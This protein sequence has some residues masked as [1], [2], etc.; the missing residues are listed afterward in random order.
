[1]L[2]CCTEL[3]N[4]LYPGT[5]QGFTFGLIPN[6]KGFHH[7]QIFIET[8]TD[9]LAWRSSEMIRLSVWPRERD[10]HT[11]RR[12]QNQNAGCNNSLIRDHRIKTLDLSWKVGPMLIWPTCSDLSRSHF[13]WQ[14]ETSEDPIVE[15]FIS[16][17]VMNCQKKFDL[18]RSL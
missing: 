10:T 1:M 11:Y 6:K 9:S 3:G 13:F 5:L 12:Y 17:V 16:S 15:D 14:L 8:E 2:L 18:E 7:G 4:H